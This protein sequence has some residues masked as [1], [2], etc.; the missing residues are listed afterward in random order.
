M[1][2]NQ[3]LYCHSC[4]NYVRFP[5]DLKIDGNHVITCPVCG[6]LHYRVVRGGRITEDRWNRQAP[7]YAV[8]SNVITYGSTSASS[9]SIT[10]ASYTTS[11]W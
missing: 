5:L 11:S 9:G 8:S 1:S 10:W 7:T 6:H 4:G 3:E 2:E